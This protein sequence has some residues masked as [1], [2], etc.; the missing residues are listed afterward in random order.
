MDCSLPGFS[1]HGISQARL[2]CHLL[3]Q[4]IFLTQESNPSLLPWQAA[5]SPL[6]HPG[7][8][9]GGGRLL[10]SVDR[11]P[12]KWGKTLLIS[13][14]GQQKQQSLIAKEEKQGV[15]DCYPWFSYLCLD[16][17]Q[18]VN[19]FKGNLAWSVFSPAQQQ[20]VDAK[21]ILASVR[22]VLS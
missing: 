20:G 21:V 11:K 14:H 3:L 18:E 8:P 1:V 4:G 5:S 17:Y 2:G 12:R 6:C 9:G 7:S 10:L 16:L 13:R 19:R 15:L 22:A